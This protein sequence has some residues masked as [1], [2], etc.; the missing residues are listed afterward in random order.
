MFLIAVTAGI[1][2]GMPAGCER[3]RSDLNW[4]HNLSVSDV[5]KMGEEG[6]E[7]YAADGAGR[8]S[9]ENTETEDG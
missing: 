5:G 3:K 8:S 9:P 4:Q 7:N 6:S 2:K 1:C